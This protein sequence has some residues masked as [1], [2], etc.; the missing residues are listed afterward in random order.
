MAQQPKKS[1]FMTQLATLIVDKRNLFFLIIIIGI[2]FSLF[3][4]NW[5]NVE[6]SLITYLPDDAE[7]KIA[8]NLMEEQFTT[9]GTAEVMVENVSGHPF[10]FSVRGGGAGRY[11]LGAQGRA[12]R[13]L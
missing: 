12:E 6:N 10:A 7:T 3:S 4:R 8:L 9:Y 2:I 11:A 5:V 13:R 1:D